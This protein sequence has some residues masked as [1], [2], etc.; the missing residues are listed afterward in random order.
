VTEQTDHNAEALRLLS[1]ASEQRGW[2][3]ESARIERCRIEAQVHS[4][5]AIA[6]GQERVAEEI[7]KLR[8]SADEQFTWWK[9]VSK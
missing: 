7:R 8:D 2:D 4:N 5:L 6:E 9:R 3:G 1:E